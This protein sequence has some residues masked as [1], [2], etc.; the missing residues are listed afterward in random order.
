VLVVCGLFRLIDSF[1]AF[2]LI[3]VLTNGGPGTVT[4]VTNYYG[5][6]QAFNFSYWGYASAIAMVI[7]AGVFALSWLI[8][9]L[10]WNA[11]NMLEPASKPRQ[12]RIALKPPQ[13]EDRALNTAAAQPR[14]P[15]WLRVHARALVAAWRCCWWCCFPF[16]WLVQL[17]FRPRP[18][19][20]TTACCSCRR[21]TAFRSLLQG[22]FA[23]PSAT[24]CW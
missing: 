8:G 11:M 3:Y 23:R 1:K 21:W 10:G 12:Q 6:I 17:A 13:H 18:T 15:G 7:L 19:S 14:Q 24:A 5:F 16:L 22:N 2:P 20:L 9:R 4:E